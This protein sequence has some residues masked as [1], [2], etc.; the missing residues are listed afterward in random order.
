MDMFILGGAGIFGAAIM[1]SQSIKPV[2]TLLQ[3]VFGALGGALAWVFLS[4]LDSF[5]AAPSLSGFIMMF[6]IGALIGAL[7]MLLSIFLFRSR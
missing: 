2:S 5:P 3:L 7:L 6:V 4:W 1:A